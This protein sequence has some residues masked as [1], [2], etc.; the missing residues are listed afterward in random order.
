MTISM[1]KHLGQDGDIRVLSYTQKN[2]VATVCGVKECTVRRWRRSHF[3]EYAARLI[4][5]EA[6]YLPW[7]AFSGLWF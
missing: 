3:P 6:G 5:I 2:Y 1:M 4:A 7:V